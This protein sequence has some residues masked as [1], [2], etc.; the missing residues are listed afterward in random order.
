VLSQVHIEDA[1]KSDA[2]FTKLMGDEVSLRKTFI[3][4]RAKSANIDD[5]DI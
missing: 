4:T 5:L 1:E 3:Q 2:I